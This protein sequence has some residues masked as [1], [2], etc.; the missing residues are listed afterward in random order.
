MRGNHG[1]LFTGMI[2]QTL[3]GNKKAIILACLAA[4]VSLINLGYTAIYSMNA[5]DMVLWPLALYFMVRLVKEQKPSFWIY[6]GIVLGISLLNKIGALFLGAGFFAALLFSKERKWFLTPWPYLCGL[7]SLVIFSPYIYW[8]I[9]HDWAHLEF[10]HNASTSKYSRLS[11]ISFLTGQLLINNPLNIPIW[12]C[13]IIYVFNQKHN[14][15]YRFIFI[16][17]LVVACNF[18]FKW[19]QQ[20]RVFSTSFFGPV[21]RREV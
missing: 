17:F 3:G 7:I 2:T 9:Q 20:V 1:I 13:G 15:A 14:R 21:H 11:P 19:N 5:I 6:I 12:I 18:S 16:V 10:I 4:V 8:N